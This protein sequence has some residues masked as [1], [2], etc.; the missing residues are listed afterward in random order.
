M[1]PPN[2]LKT[3]AVTAI[4]MKT[5]LSILF[6]TLL[7][8]ACS[9]QREPTRNFV[10]TPATNQAVAPAPTSAAK[11]SNTAIVIS[12]HANL[13]ESN[14]VRA[15]V[16]EVVPVD[17]AVEVVKQQG[18]WFYVKTETVS[19]WMH[20][21]T[22]KL[23]N[24]ELTSPAPQPARPPMPKPTVEETVENSG[25]SAKCRDGSLSYSAHRRGTCSHHGGV[26]IWY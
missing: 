3:V 4:I 12:P 21:N 20:G 1:N 19:G 11:K 22:L 5:K 16:L 10:S 17:S 6:L 18:A 24:F 2:K 14:S 13:R 9:T 25:A 15:N 7:T 8:F 26:A 23:Q